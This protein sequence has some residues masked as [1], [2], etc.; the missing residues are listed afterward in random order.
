VV[1]NYVTSPGSGGDTFAADDVGGVKTPRVKLQW[2]PDGTVNDADVATG[3]PIPVQL[4]G[5]DGTDRSNLL[6]I[7]M[8]Q[9]NGVAVLTGNGITGTGSQRVTIASDNTPF[10]VN[11][12]QSGVWSLAANQSTNMAQIN[13]SAVLT[14]NGTNTGAQRVVIASDNTAFAVNST[15]IAGTSLAT[16]NGPANGGT[17]RVVIAS[18]NNAFSVN[19]VQSGSWSLAANQS[20]NNA[21]IAGV[22]TATGNGVVGTGVQRVAIAS[23]N[24]PFGVNNAQIAGTAVSVNNGVAGTGVQRV[25]VA[26][27]QT[28]F[29][30]NAT[31]KAGTSGGATPYKYFAAASANQDSQSVKG[32]AGQLYGYD[33]FNANAAL[34][35]VK[36]YDKATAPTSA[37]TPK[38]VI[39]VPGS[40][41]GAGAVKDFANG[42][43]FAAGIGIRITTGQADNDTAAA[44]AGDVVVNLQYS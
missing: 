6:P 13:G 29:S 44:T 33:L 15:Q 30:V 40:T 24:T 32:S 37:D 39:M 14:G 10:S 35:Y 22:A 18:D 16:N 8:T 42:V 11:A 20:V 27:D 28:P 41:A 36:I 9:L 34:R 1:D 4:R 2:G 26:S 43:V 17:Q 23:D 5:S 3:K 19:A 12:V 7:N 38:L 21:Q 31:P 25:V